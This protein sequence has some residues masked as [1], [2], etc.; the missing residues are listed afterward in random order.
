MRKLIV[1]Y[2]FSFFLVP[3]T[4][5]IVDDFSDGSLIDSPAWQGDLDRFRI[6]SEAQLQLNAEMAGETSIFVNNF[7]EKAMEWNFFVQMDFNPSTSNRTRIY[8]QADDSDLLNSSGY[9]LEIGEIGGND[10]LQFYRQDNGSKVLLGKGTLGRVATLPKVN[11]RVVRLITGAWQI[12]ADFTGGNDLQLDLT[13]D[14]AT[15]NQSGTYFFGFY[16]KYTATRL[17]HFLFD[18]IL[19]TS[20]GEDLMPPALSTLNVLDEQTITLLF[21]EPVLESSAINTGNFFINKDIGTPASATLPQPNQIDLTLAIP[22]R[23]NETYTLSINNITDLKGNLLTPF[24]TTFLF[25]KI[26]AAEPYDIIINEIM[27]DASLSGGGTL[28]LPDEE[29]VELYNRSDKT[30]N[31][32]G[33]VFTDGSNRG[34]TFPNYLLLPNTYLT[35]GKTSATSL[36]EFGDFL[37]LANFPTLSGEETL[38]LQNEFGETIDIV[39]YTQDWYGNST[40]ESGGYALERI[41]IDNPC[42]RAV[43]WQGA[44]TFLGGTPSAQNS[45][46][47]TTTNLPLNLIDAYPI[48]PTQIRLYFD[49]AVDLE[50]LMDRS[51]Y[52]ISNHEVTRVSLSMDNFTEVVLEL[53]NPLIPNQ[54]ETISI[55]T[56]LEDCLGQS[57]TGQMMVSIALP[58]LPSPTDLIINEILFNPQ[59]GGVDFLELFNRSEKVIDLNGLILANQALDNPQIKAVAIPKL[60][61]PNDYIVLTES[62]LDIQQRYTVQSPTAIFTQDLPTFADQAGN[63]QLYTNNGLETIFLD[64][65]DYSDDFHTPL[66]NDKNGVSL[67][68]I[69]PDLPTQDAGN[70]HSASSSVGFATPTYQNSQRITSNNISSTIFTLPNNRISP[71]GDGFEDV[72]PINYNT[73]Q[74][75]YTATIHIYNAKGQL[76]DKI[77]QNELLATEGSFKWEGTTTDRQ[78]VPIGIYVLWIEYFNLQGVVERRKEAIVVAGKL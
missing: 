29:Y 18:N 58:V 25:T 50:S 34:A 68:R 26:E 73:P 67:E 78:K 19:I 22:L 12:F 55:A 41:D 42:L 23:N 17:T 49:K 47:G 56:T 31:L 64:E 36:A 71:D 14:D 37:G 75:G 74:T 65:F 30:I 43:N 6:N 2:I 24:D 69:N 4:A 62:P 15:Y 13:V 54:F 16:C 10:A 52:S 77:A 76:V 8:L 61:F 57:I 72:L 60:V 7:F 33:F 70:W 1:L 59:T 32:E 35:I 51:N 53:V 5:Q 38:V 20:L 45:V 39:S 21:D 48:S 11:I 28:G 3:L 46:S 63:I 66:L 40:T 44:T 9:F 27:E